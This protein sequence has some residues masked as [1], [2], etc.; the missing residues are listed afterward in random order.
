MSETRKDN[1][2]SSSSTPPDNGMTLEDRIRL[3]ELVAMASAPGGLDTTEEAI[4]LLALYNRVSDT[5]A[6][7]AEA[8]EA[9]LAQLEAPVTDEEVALAIDTLQRTARAATAYEAA[10]PF[11]LTGLVDLV[12]RLSLQLKAGREALAK[13]RDKFREYEFLHEAK[14]PPDKVKASINRDMANALDIA[15]SHKAN[16]S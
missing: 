12:R 14:S 15:L 6:A 1:Q 4:E 7:R 9:K 8:A 11:F 2:S 3:D 13:A 16:P 5:L 10:P